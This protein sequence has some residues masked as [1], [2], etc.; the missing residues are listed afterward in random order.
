M[1]FQNTDRP[2]VL[3]LQIATGGTALTLHR[4][5]HV[6]FAETT[7]TPADV[8][9]AA[10]RC[11]RIGQRSS[12][13]VRVVSLAGSIDEVVAAV[14]TRKAREL[15]ELE[16]ADQQESRM[17]VSFDIDSVDDAEAASGQCAAIADAWRLMADPNCFSQVVEVT[18]TTAAE[19]APARSRRGR[20]R[21]SEPR[22]PLRPPALR[23]PSPR[24]PL[25]PPAMRISL[26]RILSPSHPRMPT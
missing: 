5:H 12:V 22:I 8:V 17:R 14:I 15:A 3:I 20:P 19:I 26:P 25:R 13:L 6:I 10:K 2:R 7:W 9:Q 4:A 18:P 16:I 11:H 24:I 21:K 1:Q 23:L